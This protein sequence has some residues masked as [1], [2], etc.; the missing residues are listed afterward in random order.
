MERSS[1]AT[2]WI[3]A[4]TI[5]TSINIAYHVLLYCRPLIRSSFVC[6]RMTRIQ[7]IVLIYQELLTYYRGTFTALVRFASVF[8]FF[9][10]LNFSIYSL[11]ENWSTHN[12]YY[13][14]YA[15]LQYLGVPDVRSS[16]CHGSAIGDLSAMVLELDFLSPRFPPPT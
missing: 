7:L 15:I 4:V 3:C 14:F 9:F 11:I 13:S 6:L 16:P 5:N 12:E 10:H 1:L 2:D 8:S